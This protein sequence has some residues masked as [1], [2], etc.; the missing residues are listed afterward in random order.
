MI[1]AITLQKDRPLLRYLE[2]CGASRHQVENE[3]ILINEISKVHKKLL[4][5]RKMVGINRRR[6]LIMQ[7]L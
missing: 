3:K 4:C 7:F 2:K 1:S 6:Q 5:K